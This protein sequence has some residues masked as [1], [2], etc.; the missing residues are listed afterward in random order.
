MT[1]AEKA[2]ALTIAADVF[3]SDFA[4]RGACDAF[5]FRYGYQAGQIGFDQ[6][7]AGE[8]CEMIV[9]LIIDEACALRQAAAGGVQ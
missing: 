2:F 8:I 3:H 6:Q 9:G 5:R 1:D 7:R 4:L